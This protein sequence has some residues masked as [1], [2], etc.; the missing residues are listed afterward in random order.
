V[1]N[2][3]DGYLIDLT[4]RKPRLFVVENELA[5]HH[6]LKHIAVQV[7]EFS[8]SFQNEQR[9]IK[10]ILFDA[11]TNQSQYKIKCE[12]YAATHGFRNLDHLL[13]YLV[14]ENAFAAI[15]IIDEIPD[16]LE[17]IFVESFQFGVEIM[18]LGCYE[19]EK[20]ERYFQ[21][22]PFLADVTTDVRES[23]QAVSTSSR[24]IDLG[25]I[26]TVV[27]PAREDGFR[28]TFLGENRWY[29][30]RIHPSMRPQI[31]YIAAY[32]VSPLSAIT[33]IAP[34]KSI[35]PWKDSGKFVLNFTEPAHEIGPIRLLPKEQNGRVKALQNLRYTSKDILEKAKTLDDIW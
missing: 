18:E 33:H 31:K 3:P 9:G 30:V 35:E 32:Q 1:R 19:N 2:I 16:N 5:S 6:E 28:E 34:V 10:T 20:G 21:F 7:L 15:V 14:Y 29:Q 26:D 25:Q 23:A 8:I 24:L 11:L 12:Q 13:E 22:T 17:N 4:G 27:V